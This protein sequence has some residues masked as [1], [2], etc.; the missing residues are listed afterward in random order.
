MSPA[1]PA[2]ALAPPAAVLEITR[3]LEDAGHA[4]WAVGGAVRDALAGR[5]GGDWDLA[6]RARPEQVRRLF[7]RTVPIGIEHGTVGILAQDGVL[8]EVTTFRRD[9]ETTGR[10]A[11]VQFADEIEEDLSR[12][13]FTLN[14]IAWHPLRDVLLDPFGGLADLERRVLRTV[15]APD[16]RF[17]EDWL[18][19]LRGLRFAGHFALDVAPETWRSLVAATGRLGGLSA[20]RVRE[21]LWK[22]L[23]KTRP[24]SRSLSLYAASGVLA[25]LYPELEALVALEA[26][27]SPGERPW[28]ESLA[29]VDALPPARTSLR[30]AALLHRIGWPLARSKDL[31]GGWRFTG[32]ERM[33][34]RAAVELMRRLKAS[35]AETEAVSGLVGLQGELFPPDAGGW[36]VRR[37]LVAVGPE[38]VPDL[39]RLRIALWR[40]AHPAG[41]PAPGDLL[42][43]WRSARHVLRTRPPLTV[44]DLAIGGAELRELGLEP[45]P[46]YGALLRALLERVIEDPDLNTRERLLGIVREELLP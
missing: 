26:E 20:E 2:R 46:R 31:R 23:G 22:I 12:R 29:A 1:A 13:D 30:A 27:L 33:G 24:A 11:V 32:H 4:T 40:G 14:A 3:R 8:Y 17:A 34:E 44:G 5:P 28:S 36:L 42:E 15:G 19:V 45:G 35:S 6:T 41:G 37:W 21:E 25:A 10:H 7:R 38:R 16:E 18:R 43:R 9:V 39:F